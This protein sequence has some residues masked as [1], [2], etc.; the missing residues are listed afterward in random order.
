MGRVRKAS[1]MP[2]KPSLRPLRLELESRLFRGPGD[3]DGAGVVG[4]D[5][6]GV[7]DNAFLRRRLSPE[8]DGILSSSAGELLT[9][10]GMFPLQYSRRSPVQK[11]LDTACSPGSYGGVSPNGVTLPINVSGCAG[12]GVGVRDATSDVMLNRSD[13]SLIKLFQAGV[14]KALGLYREL[15]DL[16]IRRASEHGARWWSHRLV[17]MCEEAGLVRLD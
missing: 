2:A 9:E 16:E 17:E 6:S 13:A 1:T 10:R 5:H 4:A 8:T 11:M 12:F 15:V 3:Q 14:L 7:R